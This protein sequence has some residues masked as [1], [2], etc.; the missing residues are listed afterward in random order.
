MTNQIM[1]KICKY[2]NDEMAEDEMIEFF[3]ELIDAE[4][5]FSLQGHYGR[6]AMFLIDNGYCTARY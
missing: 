6:T 2:E 4:L 3:Q 5:A 1:Y